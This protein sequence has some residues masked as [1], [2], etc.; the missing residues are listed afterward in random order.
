MYVGNSLSQGKPPLIKL[1]PE[2]RGSILIRMPEA[3]RDRLD[4]IAKDFGI[5]RNEAVCRIL[6]HDPKSTLAADMLIEARLKRQMEEEQKS[7]KLISYR[8][9]KAY[10]NRVR[11]TG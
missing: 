1:S 6:A 2:Y 3:L 5:S 7:K 10:Q 9:F 11:M 4:K 8:T